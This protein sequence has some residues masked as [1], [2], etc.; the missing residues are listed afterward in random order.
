MSDPVAYERRLHMRRPLGRI[1][2]LECNRREQ[3]GYVSNISE[4]GACVEG[5]SVDEGDIVALQLARG[6]SVWRYCVAVW[7]KAGRA[8]LSFLGLP[9]VRER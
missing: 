3:E 2:S 4:T 7:S 6:S 8:G 1:A 5:A 9:F